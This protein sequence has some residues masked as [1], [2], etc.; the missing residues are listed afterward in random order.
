MLAW[1][2]QHWPLA[3]A[4]AV[5]AALGF[6]VGAL[7]LPPPPR[8]ECDP[9][10]RAYDP[11]H[12]KCESRES[13][14]QRT[15]DDPVAYFTFWLV[16]VTGVLAVVSVFQGRMLVQQTE[17]GRAEF[18]ATHR[19]R[20]R[21]RQ[22][23]DDSKLSPASTGLSCTL[24]NV[25]DAWGEMFEYNWTI[26]YGGI[27]AVEYP[28]KYDAGNIRHPTDTQYDPS[29]A[30]FDAGQERPLFLPLNTVPPM[31]SGQRPCVYGYVR[32]RDR[33]GI[34]RRTGFMREY[35]TATGRFSAVNDPDYEYED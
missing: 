14:W 11:K 32:Y 3:A 35:D 1:A 18:N 23:A 34:E 9:G 8:P 2:K 17:L 25:G 13:L 28:L 24:V 5:A 20:I 15:T 31:S 7:S 12:N 33:R 6:G 29:S 22:I 26:V 30:P 21:V 27:G 19:P 16:A 4:L 10:S